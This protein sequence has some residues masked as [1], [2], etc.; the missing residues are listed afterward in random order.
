MIIF[1]FKLLDELRH[2][3]N[4]TFYLLNSLVDYIVFVY[5]L[6][7]YSLVYLF[8]FYYLEGHKFIS[9]GYYGLTLM[10]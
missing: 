2:D 6:Y 3:Y 1:L 9:S 5:S 7:F 8:L 10:K 4:A